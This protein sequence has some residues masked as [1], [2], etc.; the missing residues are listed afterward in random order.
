VKAITEV[1]WYIGEGEKDVLAA[2]LLIKALI[3]INTSS[4]EEMV[5]LNGKAAALAAGKPYRIATGPVIVNEAKKK[6]PIHGNGPDAL[7]LSYAFASLT[8]VPD[9]TGEVKQKGAIGV[10]RNCAFN[11][12]SPE[13]CMWLSHYTTEGVLEY[14]NPDYECIFTH[15]ETS[16][17]PYCR[18]IFKKKSDPIGVI[19]DMGGTIFTLP[20]FDIPK[21]QATGAELWGLTHFL[22]DIT[23]A[24]IDLNGAE[25]TRKVLC[26]NANRIGKEFGKK[27]AEQNPGLSDDIETLGIFIKKMQNSLG[28]KDNFVI[29]SKNEVSN[30]ITDCSHQLMCGEQCKQYEAFCKGIVSAINPNFEFDYDKMMTHGSKTCHW[31]L[32]KKFNSGIKPADNPLDVLRMRFA[33]GEISKEEFKEMKALLEG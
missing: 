24:F 7:L 18:Y 28:Q 19:D 30:E 20:K 2:N 17:D 14:L 1:D 31:V 9:V 5:K 11:N 33:K 3:E 32:R 27:L 29:L 25:T 6:M 26:A 10:N 15:H 16:G 23:S 22:N 8:V 4:F 13:F 21:E 12:A